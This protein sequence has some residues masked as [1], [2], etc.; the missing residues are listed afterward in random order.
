DALLAYVE[1][2]R[3]FFRSVSGA[4][5]DAYHYAIF[6]KNTPTG[7]LLGLGYYPSPRSAIGWDNRDD[8]NAP[9]G[10]MT[11]AHEIGHN[12]GRPHTWDEAAAPN[13]IREVG[14]DVYAY[15]TWP[16]NTIACMNY[17]APRW[18]SDYTWERLFD[19][20]SSSPAPPLLEEG[21]RQVYVIA[22]VGRRDGSGHL[23]PSYVI[24][25][26]EPLDASNEAGPF[27]IQLRTDKDELLYSHPFDTSME[28]CYS[29]NATHI[30]QTEGRSPFAFILPYS[31]KVGKIQLKLGEQLIDELVAAGV[32]MGVTVTYPNGG[33]VLTPSDKIR[34]TA[35]DIPD[36]TLT[37]QLFYSHNAGQT[38]EPMLGGLPAVVTPLQGYKVSRINGQF[39]MA[40]D[41]EAER[42]AGSGDMLI[43][44]LAS[45][46]VRTV[47]D[48]SDGTFT[49][50]SKPPIVTISSPFEGSKHPIGNTVVFSGYAFDKEDQGAVPDEKLSWLWKPEA[51]GLVEF[52]TGRDAFL[53]DIPEGDIKVWFVAEDS[54]G[55]S[56]TAEIT[57]NGDTPILGDLNNNWQ[58]DGGDV[59]MYGAI[60]SATSGGENFYGIAD[61]D[62]DGIIDNKDVLLL[63]TNM[64]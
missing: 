47:E 13:S 15:R 20:R 29:T 3:A 5:S 63:L 42:M 38:W 48:I 51:A 50:E 33:E 7:G 39:E 49:V 64:N 57:I 22:G 58:L 35:T 40:L 30:A 59:M 26:G 62:A 1:S 8:P 27:F 23:D 24:E 14:V 45:D 60:W 43:R 55:Q 41:S 10:G 16:T 2:Q 12:H 36:V 53:L 25:S 52:A 34:W 6:N 32:P 54:D 9:R 28:A 46:G 4:P 17:G 11:M 37:F 18:V 21:K 19:R 61:I 31:N 44:V 56:A